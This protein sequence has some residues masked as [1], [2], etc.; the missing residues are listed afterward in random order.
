[1]SNSTHISRITLVLVSLSAALLQVAID[2]RLPGAGIPLLAASMAIAIGVRFY[3]GRSPSEDW[4]GWSVAAIVALAL[5]PYGWEFASRNFVGVGQPLEVQLA[6]ML[7]NIMLGLAAVQFLPRARATTAL[8]SLFLVVVGFL[9]CTNTWTTALL[10]VYAAVGMWWLVGTY[11]ERLGGRFADE[12]EPSAPVRPAVLAG[13]AIGIVSLAVA[14]FAASSSATTALA[15]F[16]PSSGGT[17]WNDPFAHGGV[18]DGDQMVA[19]EDNA[20]SF[21]PVESD[22][23]L[24]SKMPSLYDVFN[25]FSEPSTPKKRKLSRR[26]IPLAPSSMQINH[27]KKG[28]TQKATREFSTVRQPTKRRS[29][30]ED[31]LSKSL[32]LVSGQTPLHLALET[33]DQW[34]GR[35]LIAAD[36]TEP[37]SLKLRDPDKSGRRWVD[38]SVIPPSEVFTTQSETQVRVVNLRTD[39]VPSPPNTTSVT[40]DRLHSASMFSFASDGSLAMQVEHIPQLSILRLRSALRDRS[41]EPALVTSEAVSDST[42]VSDLATSWTA[43]VPRG[44]PQVQVVVDRLRSEYEHDPKAMIPESADDAVEHFLVHAKR[45]PDYLFAASAAVMLRSLG[46]ETRVRGGLYASPDRY[47]R[48]SRLT[49]VLPEDVHFWVE[50][51]SSQGVEFTKE[52]KTNHGTWVTIE[53]TPGYDV[54]YA[55]ESLFAFWARIGWQALGAVAAHPVRSI[56]VCCLMGLLVIKRRT[57]LDAALSVVWSVQARLSGPRELAC[58]TLRVFEWRAWLYGNRRPAGTPIGRWEALAGQDVFLSAVGWALYGEGTA[59][60]LPDQAIRD[61]CRHANRTKFEAPSIAGLQE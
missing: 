57:L 12:T 50:V 31:Y 24:E 10:V 21:G 8:A 61:A 33:F 22:L 34:D 19:A 5:L 17:S 20:S 9:W 6:C 26:A 18:G 7:R 36:S 2:N 14:P 30:T 56:V 53:P 3:A 4:A 1:M 25:E 13:L 11:W 37:L 55:P 29:N 46:Y 15:G 48:V 60:P 16:F 43:G 42:L 58:F 47:D 40:L 39:R 44:W 54:L 32:L 35:S 59:P 28:I 27:Q 51:K 49:T 52:G 23:F 41:V 45:G 38:L